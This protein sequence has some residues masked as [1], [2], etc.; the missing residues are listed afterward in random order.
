MKEQIS[1]NNFT[2][3]TCVAIKVFENP[4]VGNMLSCKINFVNSTIHLNS[5]TVLEATGLGYDIESMSEQIN[6]SI[7][8]KT[9]FGKIST[10]MML[11]AKH[12]ESMCPSLHNGDS[13]ILAYARVTNTTLV[14]CDKGLA[15][16]AKISGTASIN[17]D[18]LASDK[19]GQ[20]IK[21]KMQKIVDRT[22]HKPTETKHKA[23][24]L[25]LKPGQKI[26]WRSFQ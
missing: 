5:Q 19:I 12:L 11:D 14:T 9:V 4:N 7:G 25:V 20:I 2:F 8:A 15:E 22:I 13:Q 21:S 24:T 10:E 6:Q 17:P 18:L 23:R 3:D 26:I 1:E 16:A